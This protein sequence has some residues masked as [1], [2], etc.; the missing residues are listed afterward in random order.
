[1]ILLITGHA[2]LKGQ[3]VVLT[4]NFSGFTTGTHSAPT[5]YDYGGSLDSKTITPGWSGYKI[6]SA[7]GEIKIGTEA[8]TGWIETPS[9]D[10]TLNEGNFRVKFD[11]CRWPGD[12]ASVKVL[13]NG[14]PIGNTLIPTD[15]FETVEFSGTGGTA[16][17]RIKIEGLT[18][19]F[20]LDNFSVTVNNLSTG[21][22]PNDEAIPGIQIFPVP[23]HN[24]LYLNRMQHVSNIEICDI[25]GRAI[26]IIPNYS[27]EEMQLEVG[28]LR[29]GIYLIRFISSKGV[30]VRRI[31]K[32]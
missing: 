15:N 16:S 31:I 22:R 5:T 9:I 24:I 30:Q 26:K 27:G 10:L 23:V 18:K 32:I 3:T 13:L 20:F 4:E 11:I 14:I 7:G 17:S 25:S 1:M 8:I 6:N 28:N 12:D 19:R 2:C 29:E 21:M